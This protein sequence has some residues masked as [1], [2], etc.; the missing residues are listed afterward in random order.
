M[1]PKT[2]KKNNWQMKIAHKTSD[3]LKH[4][5]TSECSAA[6]FELVRAF[7]HILSC[8]H[9][10]FVMISQTVQK[11]SRSQTHTLTLTN[12]HYWKQPTSPRYRG[13][14]GKNAGHVPPDISFRTIVPPFLRG[15]GH[16]PLPPPPSANLQIECDLPLTSTKLI[17]VDRLWSGIQVSATFQKKIPSSVGPLGLGLGSGIRVSARLKNVNLVQD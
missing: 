2:G 9:K 16:F 10:N 13:A 7:D 14:A 11:V 15:V 4:R 3:T 6:I 12:G 8:S 1:K 17:V 5:S